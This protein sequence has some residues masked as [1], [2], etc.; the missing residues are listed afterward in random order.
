[1]AERIDGG[2][3]SVSGPDYAKSAEFAESIT[4]LYCKRY[5]VDSID[6]LSPSQARQMEI[7]LGIVRP[8]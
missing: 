7:E 4:A 5:A 6:K 2:G 3:L 1:M 8:K